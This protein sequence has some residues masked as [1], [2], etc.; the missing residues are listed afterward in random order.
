MNS[1]FSSSDIQ[2]GMDVYDSTGEKI[3]SISDVYQNAGMGGTGGT[4]TWG[5]SNAG[6]GDVI[7][8]EIDVISTP[9]YNA[10]GS[11]IGGTGGFDA[12]TGTTGTSSFDTTGTAGYGSGTDTP[13]IGATGGFGGSGTSAMG[14]STAGTGTG[15]MTFT[16]LFKISEGGILGIGATDLY[17]PFSAVSNIN[18]DGVYL[19]CTKDQAEQQYQQ[20][21]DFLQNGDN[22]N[23]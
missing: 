23:I 9:D 16:G 14:T 17:I 18:A 10:G 3:G 8:E 19:N 13:S 15:T 1:D 5:S 20:Q 22:T 7:V 2:K 11:N 4:G 12:G 21:P 6:T